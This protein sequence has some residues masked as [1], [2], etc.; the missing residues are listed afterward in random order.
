[1]RSTLFTPF[2]VSWSS[3]TFFS[4][5][6]MFVCF[7]LC[8]LFL[9]LFLWLKMKQNQIHSLKPHHLI[10]NV[11][12]PWI[13]LLYQD[14]GSDA[15]PSGSA[16]NEIGLTDWFMYVKWRA[17]R[18]TKRKH[19][20]WEWVRGGESQIYGWSKAPWRGEE[21]IGSDRDKWSVRDEENEIQ[22]YACWPRPF[23]LS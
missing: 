20:V 7:I 3:E 19:W 2:T 1:M 22:T 5:N 18:Q 16:L 12:T 4:L 6:F 11:I 9:S 23:F 10:W 13:L 17:K 14:G 15:D 8:V 21:S